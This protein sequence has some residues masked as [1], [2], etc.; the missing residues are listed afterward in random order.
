MT[1]WM[2]EGFN[3]LFVNAVIRLFGKSVEI[4]LSR[5]KKSLPALPRESFRVVV[6]LLKYSFADIKNGFF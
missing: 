2:L 4:S 3:W 5:P 1:N 6:L